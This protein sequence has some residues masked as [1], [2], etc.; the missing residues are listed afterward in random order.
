MHQSIVKVMT[1]H[2]KMQYEKSGNKRC[3]RKDVAKQDA[4]K[5][6]ASGETQGSLTAPLC[7][8]IGKFFYGEIMPELLDVMRVETRKEV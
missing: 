4:A 3:I 5:E 8:F 6:S 7:S 2:E 1:R